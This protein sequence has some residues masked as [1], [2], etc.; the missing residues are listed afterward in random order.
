MLSDAPDGIRDLVLMKR[1]EWRWI[2]GLEA[3]LRS[4]TPVDVHGTMSTDDWDAYQ[5]GMRAQANVAG[6]RLARLIPVPRGARD[7]LDIGGSHGYWSV[8][9]CRRHPELR[10]TVFDLPAAVERAAPLLAREGM[11][12][13]VVHK[14]GDALT[15]DLGQEAYDLIIMFSLVH[16]FDEA[17]NRSLVARAGEA[18]RPGGRM[19]IFEP[20]RPRP[21]R[22]VQAG[23]I[24]RPLLRNDERV[25]NVDTGGDERLAGR[26][27]TAASQPAVRPPLHRGGRPG[28][29]GQAHDLTRSHHR[30]MA[31]KD[32]FSGHAADYAR[33]RPSYP[34]ELFAWL[35]DVSPARD[36]AVDLGTGNG[37]AAVGLADHF[38]R[39]IGIEPSAEQLANARPHPKVEYRVG[40]AEATG[41]TDG[42]AD[43]LLAAQA[44]HWFQREPFFIEARRVL[45]PSGVLALVS[46]LH[47]RITPEVDA[48]VE[49]L[50]ASLDPYWEPERRLVE[51]GYAGVAVPFEELETPAF[52][53]RSSWSVNDLIGYMGTWSALRKCMAAEGR[54]PLD[55]VRPRLV[56]A[57][58][59][60]GAQGRGLAA[61]RP[62]VPGGVNGRACRAVAIPG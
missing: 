1:L 26:C 3:Y 19:V 61:R 40:P 45:R 29:R 9:L 53:M 5:R 25:R 37:Q 33:F 58:G 2:D 22:G 43:L 11:G 24:L 49:E 48:V 31:F 57:W 35:A 44:F 15:D 27:R 38:E 12:D 13:R 36:L 34:P 42:A 55:D 4:G 16:H 21:G 51:D 7:M 28:G 20:L 60:D 50:Y 6:P 56:L 47:S 32:L 30:S 10:A 41:L 23:A 54:D 59:G 18:L 14:A 39:V 62:R 17:T 52:E 46:Y 8:L